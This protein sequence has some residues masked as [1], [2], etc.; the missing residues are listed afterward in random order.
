MPDYPFAAPPAFGQGC[1]VAPG[2]TWLRMPLPFALDHVNLW[3]LEDGEGWA[4]VDTGVPDRATRALW[5]GLFGGLMAGRPLTRLLVTHFHPDHMGLADWLGRRFAVPMEAPL[6]EWLYGRMLSLDASPDFVEI[7]LAFYRD[8]GFPPD[9][10]ELVARRGNAYGARIRHIPPACR[11]LRDGEALRFGGRAWRVLLAEGHS[12]AMACFYCPDDNLLISGDQVLPAISPN[13]SLWPNQPDADPLGLFLD[14]FAAF[15]ALPDDVLVLPS[16]GRPFRGL[17]P[18][19]DEL[20]RHHHDRLEA[21]RQACA[22]PKSAYDLLPLLFAR[23]LDDHQLFFAIGESLAHL[24]FLERRGQLTA[25]PGDGG[26][27]LYR[28]L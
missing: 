17:K 18:R 20:E 19:L 11:A 9:L 7:S 26:A 24:R 2:L 6:A 27:R 22:T 1:L 16:H 28:A 25:G 4:L 21:V 10:L 12:P 15:R 5:E 13:V 8:A 3:L 23:A 14:S